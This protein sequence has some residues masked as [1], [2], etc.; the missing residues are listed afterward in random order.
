MSHT[1]KTS[2]TT[3]TRRTLLAGTAAGIAATSLSFGL[4]GVA[5]ANTTAAAS[6]QAVDAI[7][8]AH[9]NELAAHLKTVLSSTY[10]DEN[11]KNK[12]LSTSHCPHCKVA[13]APDMMDQLAFSVLS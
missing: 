3:L 8:I 4:A 10:V 5:S 11:M 1:T 7:C 12:L 6:G 2:P 13:I 9:H